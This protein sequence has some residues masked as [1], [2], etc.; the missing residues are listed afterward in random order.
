MSKQRQ[1]ARAARERAA[2]QRAAAARDE[3]RRLARVRERREA[4]RL[5]WR[6]LRLWQHGPGF[7]RRREQWGALTVVA[8]LVLIVVYV[9]TGSVV[10]VIG[11]VLALLI[12][13]PVLVS[14]FMDRSRR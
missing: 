11:A 13:L 14:L 7:H 2:Q 9:V 3:Q 1:Q 10:D 6:R 5:R 4:R 12:C 8:F